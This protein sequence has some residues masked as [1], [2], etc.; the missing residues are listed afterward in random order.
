MRQQQHP[1][2]PPRTRNARG[3]EVLWFP[4]AQQQNHN[5]CTRE[6]GE[7]RRRERRRT[8]GSGANTKRT[9]THSKNARRPCTLEEHF[10][11][12]FLEGKRIKQ[13]RERYGQPPS[14]RYRETPSSCQAVHAA[15]L[16]SRDD[17]EQRGFSTATKLTLT[18]LPLWHSFSPP[19]L[20]VET[21]GRWLFFASVPSETVARDASVL[22]ADAETP[23]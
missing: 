8:G 2:P 11:S 20:T 21:H 18:Y 10:P 3:N 12:I 17:T 19:P 15:T 23:T 22:T 13:Q 9:H 6:G 7:E 4:S 16:A 5:N 1:A 14:C